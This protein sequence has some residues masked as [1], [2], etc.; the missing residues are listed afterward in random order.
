MWGRNSSKKFVFIALRF[1][2]VNGNFKCLYFTLSLLDVLCK[3]F[4]VADDVAMDKVAIKTPGYT[5]NNIQF[6]INIASKFA[7]SRFV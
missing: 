5:Y 3:N 4:E 1:I 6:L 2:S 7:I